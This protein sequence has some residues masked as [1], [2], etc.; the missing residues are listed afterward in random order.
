ME[1][2]FLE[3]DIINK[4]P[5]PYSL[6]ATPYVQPDFSDLTKRICLQEWKKR[7]CT[8]DSW[9]NNSKCI[10]VGDVSVGKTCLINRFCRHYFD[11]NYKATIGVDFELE[12][13]LV[14]DSPFNLQIWDTAGQE[15]FKSIAQSYY[16]GANAVILMF[17]LTN[18]ESLANCK[19]W[20][21]ETL[22]STEL[23]PFIFL[24]GSKRDLLD[25]AVYSN[26]KLH[27]L[28]FAKE[29]NAEYWSVSS[30]TGKNVSKLFRRIAA[31]CFD[32]VT[33]SG[34]SHNSNKDIIIGHHLSG[35]R[36]PNQK[37]NRNV[38]KICCSA[39]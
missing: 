22:A 19:K 21:S 27:A 8:E 5:V 10:L 3:H 23:H 1:D 30:K 12:K 11:S 38:G 7:N 39:N 13:F 6:E 28:K 37:T 25:R 31:L 33:Q 24:V 35:M 9:I 26:M 14:L 20:A 29:L 18:C 17:D 2:I 16:R 32:K 4:F 15:R 34:N 36:R